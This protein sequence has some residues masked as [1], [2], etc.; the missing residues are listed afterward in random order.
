MNQLTTFDAKNL[1]RIVDALGFSALGN[2][3]DYS[4]LSVL[5]QEKK[6]VRGEIGV[7]LSNAEAHDFWRYRSQQYD[8]SFLSGC[9]AGEVKE[10]FYD[11]LAKLAEDR[12]FTSDDLD[13]VQ[14][15]DED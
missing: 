10:Y 9:R 5:K 1:Q 6:Y 14:P 4:S 2:N 3:G 7:D 8:A 15:Y 13:D 11:W 12:G